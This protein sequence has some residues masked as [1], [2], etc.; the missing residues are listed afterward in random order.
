MELKMKQIRVSRGMG[1][2]EVAELAGMQVRR[3]GS[4]ERGERSITLDDAA[5]IADALQ[6]SLDELA[7]RDWPRN[8]YADKRQAQLNAD[9]E[10]MD[11]PGKAAAANAVRGIAAGYA[12]EKTTA[13]GPAAA[14]GRTA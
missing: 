11:E 12:R 9:Y 6:C 2:K 3:Y 8:A 13:E 4:Y 14:T 1:Q 10:Y 7:G 5:M